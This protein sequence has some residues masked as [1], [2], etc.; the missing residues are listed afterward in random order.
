MRLEGTGP[1]PLLQQTHSQLVAQHY[2]HMTFEN[3][4]DEGWWVFLVSIVILASF[5]PR[6]FFLLLILT[7]TYNLDFP[8]GL[9][10][11]VA[12]LLWLGKLPRPTAELV[13]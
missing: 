10:D 1:S 8:V 11:T 4:E 6:P 3:L 9:G 5:F 12:V 13:F 7:Q 2:V